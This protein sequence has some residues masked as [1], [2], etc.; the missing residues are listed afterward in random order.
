MPLEATPLM[1]YAKLTVV[2]VEVVGEGMKICKLENQGFCGV[3]TFEPSSTQYETELVES[4]ALWKIPKL[5]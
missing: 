4:V 1:E 3:I 2:A 5:R